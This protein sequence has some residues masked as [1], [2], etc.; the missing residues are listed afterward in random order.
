[1]R[2]EGF[3]AETHRE[4]LGVLAGALG[5]GGGE[6]GGSAALHLL[7]LRVEGKGFTRVEDVR[8]LRDR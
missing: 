1:M 6:A 8:S 4:R 3:A 5:H 7:V 2:L